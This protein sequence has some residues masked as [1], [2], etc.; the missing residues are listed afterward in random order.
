[1]AATSTI[2]STYLK[3]NRLEGK[4]LSQISSQDA[5]IYGI[6]RPKINPLCSKET[7]PSAKVYDAVADASLALR[8]LPV[9]LKGIMGIEVPHSGSPLTGL[10]SLLY[11]VIGWARA[12]DSYKQ[13]KELSKM[14]DDFNASLARAQVVGSGSIAAGSG[15]LAVVRIVHI[16]EEFLHFTVPSVSLPAALTTAKLAAS[17]I[18][19][20]LYLVFY[21][22]YIVGQAIVLKKLSNG[23]ALREK[24]LGSPD[25]VKALREHID[26]EMFRL[27]NFS[28][29]ECIEMALQEGER[30]LKKL[31]K[32]VKDPSWEPNSD[33]RREHAYHLMYNH[34]EYMMAEMGV[35]EDFARAAP[36]EKIRRFGLY[37]GRKRLAAKIEN[38]LKNELG[39]DAIKAFNQKPADFTEALSSA[40]WGKW[41]PRT[42][43]VLKIGLAVASAA[44]MIVATIGTGGLAVAIPLVVLG[45]VGLVWLVAGGD[46][47]AFIEQLR[48][49]EV[50]KRDKILI[51]LSTVLSLIALGALI[52]LTVLSGGAVI[53]IAGV[54]FALGW[55]TINVI[56]GSIL[57]HYQ[58]NPWRYQKEVT[59]AAFRKFLEKQRTE[60]EIKEIYDKMSLE[61]RTGIK[62]E[63]STS[64]TLQKAAKSWENFLRDLR[65]ESLDLL[66]ERLEAVSLE[67]VVAI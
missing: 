36:E 6:V 61:N 39:S 31:E 2:F 33:S 63:L 20:V 1:M 47:A 7:L 19:T 24:L 27:G 13:A 54:V 49:G 59:V 25:P 62:Q 67:N 65:A 64:D 3:R 40:D 50:S 46:G 15:F 23:D 16:I 10:T 53:Y 41:G 9:G 42:K 5:A 30:W 32:E 52:A 28:K 18:S 38:D 21:L 17:I 4:P 29:D 8:T 35:T 11:S 34:P 37:I 55:L 56:S 48:S 22:I 51:L 26:V 58:N 43:A 14:G 57:L 44:A 12:R 66:K 60:K 45:V